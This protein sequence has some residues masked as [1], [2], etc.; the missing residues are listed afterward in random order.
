MRTMRLLLLLSLWAAVP[1]PSGA[2]LIVLTPE[3]APGTIV[4]DAGLRVAAGGGP[5]TYDINVERSAGFV[6]RLL[7]VER[8]SGRVVLRQAPVCDG[9]HY[10]DLFTLYVD[11][12]AN[13]TLEY[14]SV[15][16]RVLVKG[17]GELV[18]FEGHGK[19][20]EDVSCPFQQNEAF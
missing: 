18:S 11:S 1:A 20:E 10:P 15:P 7:H 2:Y 8:R 16:L 6:R 3:D 14:A 9:L 5:R 17:C 4:F 19:E 13:S 12:T